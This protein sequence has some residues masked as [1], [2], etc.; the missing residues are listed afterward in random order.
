MNGSMAALGL[1]IRDIPKE[2]LDG[3]EKAMNQFIAELDPLAST[4][5]REEERARD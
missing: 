1:D 3:P 5:N 2:K 4:G